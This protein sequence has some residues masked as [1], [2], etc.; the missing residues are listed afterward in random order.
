M[1]DMADYYLDLAIDEMI[2]DSYDLTWRGED[3]PLGSPPTKKTCRYCGERG[4]HWLSKDGINWR[5]VNDGKE[6]HRCLMYSSKK[7]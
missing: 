1:G 6:L 7:Q 4:L 2:E 5:L 3:P